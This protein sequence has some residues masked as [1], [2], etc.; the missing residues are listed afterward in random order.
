MSSTKLEA[1][2]FEEQFDA[3]QNAR[4]LQWSKEWRRTQHNQKVAAEDSELAY[5]DALFDAGSRIQI[6]GQALGIA[7]LCIF[8]YVWFIRTNARIAKLELANE[9]DTSASA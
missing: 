9:S 1:R 5:A 3:L 6:I 8:A 4:A 7:A 2:L